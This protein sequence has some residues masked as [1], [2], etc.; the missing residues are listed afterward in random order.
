MYKRE[1]GAG[2]TGR[3][4]EGRRDRGREGGREMN[5]SQ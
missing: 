5:S 4:K 3:R 2:R 1:V